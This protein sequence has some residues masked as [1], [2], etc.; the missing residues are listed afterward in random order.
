MSNP[1]IHGR[2]RTVPASK[3]L[4]TLGDS[5]GRIKARDELTFVDVGRVLGRGD[6]AAGKYAE[7]TA[8]MG[9]VAFLLG[10]AA[11]DGS[12]ANDVFALIGMQLSPTESS[13]ATDRDALIALT[14]L[15]HEVAVALA[16]DGKIDDREL[17]EMRH[18]LEAAG[19]AIDVLRHRLRLRVVDHN[20]EREAG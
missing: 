11:W 12:F 7:G 4:K 5:L 10:C 15:L 20:S 13:A 14:G 16:D 6:D 9:V 18:A 3:L 19:R 8:E 2:Y 17:A 1:L